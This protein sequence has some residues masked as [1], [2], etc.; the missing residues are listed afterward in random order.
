MLTAEAFASVVDSMGWDLNPRATAMVVHSQT[1]R[2]TYLDTSRTSSLMW[3][4]ASAASRGLKPDGSAL[5][6]RD[7]TLQRA[8]ASQKYVEATL[9]LVMV[10]E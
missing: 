1:I 10:A 8:A 9:L 3:L 6:V 5:L 7:A 4:L 2:S